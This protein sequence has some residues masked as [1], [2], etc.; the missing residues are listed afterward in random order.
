MRSG[1]EVVEC[2]EGG[3]RLMRS[4]EDDG[5]LLTMLGMRRSFE[6]T[7]SRM[8]KSCGCCVFEYV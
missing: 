8:M 2:L 7:R 4:M 1:Y 3:Q 6:G 5:R